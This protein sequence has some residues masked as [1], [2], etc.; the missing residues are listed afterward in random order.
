MSVSI[1]VNQYASEHD[2]QSAS[3]HVSPYVRQ[4]AFQPLPSN[5]KYM[6]MAPPKR[7]NPILNHTKP[8]F[9]GPRG[10]Q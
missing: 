8:R 4:M 7:T 9:L 6:P 5:T 3:I 2:P 10:I 1:H